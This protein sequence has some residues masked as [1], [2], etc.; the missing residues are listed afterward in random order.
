MDVR[1]QTN[2]EVSNDA[3]VAET[4]AYLAGAV[5]TLNA[6]TLVLLYNAKLEGLTFPN[7]NVKQDPERD[8]GELVTKCTKL[9]GELKDKEDDGSSQPVSRS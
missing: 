2:Q 1:E 3:V 6:V 4:L 8:L 5:Q 7:W 9:L